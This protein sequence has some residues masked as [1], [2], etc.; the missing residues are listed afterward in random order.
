MQGLRQRKPENGH[1]IGVS[2]AADTATKMIS[3]QCASF[4]VDAHG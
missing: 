1:K 3:G 2:T 4:A